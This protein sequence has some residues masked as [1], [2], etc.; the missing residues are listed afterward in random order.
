MTDWMAALLDSAD[1]GL[2][3]WRHADSTPMTD[4]WL[5]FGIDPHVRSA[6]A[7]RLLIA[8]SDLLPGADLGPVPRFR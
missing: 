6:P 2:V 1:L 5:D 3:R 4:T 8:E 7:A